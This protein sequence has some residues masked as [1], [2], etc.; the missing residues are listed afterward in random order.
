MK[1]KEY[2]E[3][4][5]NECGI[6]VRYYDKVSI[7]MGWDAHLKFGSEKPSHNKAKVQN[8]PCCDGE[9]RVSDH[10]AGGTKRCEHCKGAGKF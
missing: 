5:E 6:D 3:W 4:L 9:G 1:F 7:E 8:C 10:N 2:W